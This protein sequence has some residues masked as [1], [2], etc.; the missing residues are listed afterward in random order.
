[1]PNTDA[2]RLDFLQKLTDQARYTGK[3]CLRLSNY[4]RGWRLYETSREDAKPDIR[5]VIDEAMA[6]GLNT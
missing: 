5:A 1:M 6:K 2:E 4:Q 3:V